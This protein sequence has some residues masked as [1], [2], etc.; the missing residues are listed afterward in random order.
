MNKTGGM[1]VLS[2][3]VRD[4]VIVTIKLRLMTIH[5]SHEILVQLKNIIA[6]H[7]K[8]IV[9]NLQSVDS[10]DSTSISMLVELDHYLKESGKVLT[11]A[12]LAPFVKKTFEMLHITKFFNIK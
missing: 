4:D 12:N 1:G 7:D 2:V 3:E 11:L 6:E 5:H 9:L 8:N 10:I